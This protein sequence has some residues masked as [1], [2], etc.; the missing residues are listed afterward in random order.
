MK[1]WKISGIYLVI[2]GCFHNIPV[3]K[4]FWYIIDGIIKD[5]VLFSI[6]DNMERR[7][8]VF[9]LLS[10]FLIIFVGLIFQWLINLSKQP[11]PMWMG[12]VLLLHIISSW[13]NI[14]AVQERNY[15]CLSTLCFYTV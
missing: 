10:G 4:K 2:V 8:I 14:A 11:L 15:L 9:Y 6:D 7:F 3:L 13:Y 1:I 12:W 5:G